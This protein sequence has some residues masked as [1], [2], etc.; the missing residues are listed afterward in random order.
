VSFTQYSATRY[1]SGIMS[2]YSQLVIKI[3]ASSTSLSEEFA[4]VFLEYK[5]AFVSLFLSVI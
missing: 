1:S 5:S 2:M 4:G 3:F